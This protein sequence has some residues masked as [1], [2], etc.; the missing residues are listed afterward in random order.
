MD[1]A[2]HVAFDKGAQEAK[3]QPV[4][5][6]ELEADRLIDQLIQ[7]LTESGFRVATVPFRFGFKSQMEKRFPN[8]Y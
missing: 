2:A 3:R 5:L 8:R 1:P 6:P 7:N 4:W